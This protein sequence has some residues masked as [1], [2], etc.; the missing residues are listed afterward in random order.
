MSIIAATLLQHT[1]AQQ[2]IEDQA[3]WLTGAPHRPRQ[4]TAR[5]RAM[6]AAIPSSSA[7]GTS[8]KCRYEPSASSIVARS[9]AVPFIC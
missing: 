3:A 7:D 2:P 6:R 5:P 4:D 1:P 8:A 9:R